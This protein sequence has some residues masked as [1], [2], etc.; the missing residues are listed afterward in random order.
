MG[1]VIGTSL[2]VVTRD[3]RHHAVLEEVLGRV[4]SLLGDPAALDA[5]RDRIR[6]ELPTLARFFQA[7]TYLLRRLVEASS[8]LVKDVRDD[9]GHALRAE[10][11]RFVAA[12]VDKLK[13]SPDYREQV[14]GLKRDL[15][16]RA[17]LRAVLQEGWERFVVWLGADVRAQQG[18]IRPAFET[19]LDDFAQR[20]QHDP[21]LRARLNHWLAERASS[22]TER[23]KHEVAAFVAA[24]VK[25][26]DTQHAVRTIE[27]SIGRDLQYIRVN[28][29]LV[30]GL[31][32]LAIFTATRLALA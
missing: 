26:W 32:G 6:A 27:L 7:D 18:I 30:G 13:R 12:F 14:E 23:Y 10:F 28:G 2:E 5:I 25:S 1:Q 24:Q 17:E 21:G 22:I 19:F 15:L 9:P 8:A 4:E 31:L 11:D 29:A 20:L 16:A 3:R